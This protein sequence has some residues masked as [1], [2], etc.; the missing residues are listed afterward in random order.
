MDR[1]F[2]AAQLRQRRLGIAA[3]VLA[4]LGLVAV[5][6]WAAQHW[7][8]PSIERSEIRTAIVERGPLG[9]SQPTLYVR[10]ADYQRLVGREGQINQ[11]LVA[12]RG[13]NSTSV[14]LS[15]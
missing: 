5:L 8:R 1:E 14:Q 2:S 4:A 3:R 9:G 15:A 10:L 6:G 12:N 13:E 7:L 11:I